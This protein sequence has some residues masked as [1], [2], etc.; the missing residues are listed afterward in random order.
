MKILAI[1]T[2]TE[3]CSAAVSVDDVISER[4]ALAPRE[5]SSLI[6]GMIQS[7]LAETG[8][9]LTELDALAFTRGPGAFTG[10]RI[11]AGV[12]QGIAFATDLPV[13]PVSTLAA[14]AQ[15]IYLEKGI[16]RALTALDARMQEVY[17]GAYRIS[18]EGIAIL[19]GQE[20]VCP[21]ERAPVPHG[22]DWFGV[23]PGWRSYQEALKNRL[24]P[25]VNGWDANYHPR[26]RAVAV[27]G[28]EAYLRNQMVSA[29]QALPVYL[30]DEVAHN[31][32]SAISISSQLA[33][34]TKRQ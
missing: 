22:Q 23:G 3:A 14:L 19:Q 27:L 29:E 10:V 24:G 20:A 1:D 31:K 21:P 7:L 5:H 16:T 2:S 9:V 8:L 34:K 15:G 6:L 17:W 26:A 30:R 4:F 25:R 18:N 32:R 12:A 28:S 33:A 13:V 11:A